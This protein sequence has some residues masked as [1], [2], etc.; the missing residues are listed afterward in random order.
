MSD[1][2][3]TILILQFLNTYA[4]PRK[5][6]Y[7]LFAENI[8][9][10]LQMNKCV[11]DQGNF[12]KNDSNRDENHIVWC[13][14]LLLIRSLSTHLLDENKVILDYGMHIDS[15][16]YLRSLIGFLSS[17]GTDERVQQLVCYC[18]QPQKDQ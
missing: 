12:Y 9:Q 11:Y 5:G 16:T 6:A 15:E 14:V 4:G 2:E 1:V 3:E 7:H 13:H 18:L 10:H 8:F 17:K